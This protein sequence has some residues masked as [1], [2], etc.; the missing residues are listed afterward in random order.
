VHGG[1]VG[2]VE[3]REGTGMPRPHQRHEIGITRARQSVR[4][5][6]PAHRLMVSHDVTERNPQ[7]LGRAG[8][9]GGG[10]NG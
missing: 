8:P 6:S 4:Y 3:R 10:P 2:L 9:R 1:G 7:S 5:P